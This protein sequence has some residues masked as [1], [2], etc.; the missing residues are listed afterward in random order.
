MSLQRNA[1]CL[2]LVAMVAVAA[3]LLL[4]LMGKANAAYANQRRAA[5]AAPAPSQAAWTQAF[6]FDHAAVPQAVLGAGW[7]AP[8]P[9]A[10]VWSR[11]RRAVL[12]LPPPP[13]AG[14]AEVALTVEA[15]VVAARPLQRV[16]ARAGDRTLGEWRLTSAAPTTL[17]FAAPP[18]LRAGGG[19][20]AVQLELPD[21]DSPKRVEGAMDARLLAIRLRRIDVAG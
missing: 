18:E 20:L 15:Y 12:R 8:E 11:D 6:H 19:D 4:E 5:A 21:A 3:F 1:A 9:G 14:P 16:V 10:G 7:S 2:G 13:V 17:R